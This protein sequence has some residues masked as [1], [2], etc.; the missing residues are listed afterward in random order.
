METDN[1][2]VQDLESLEKLVFSKWLFKIIEILFWK[3]LKYPKMDII[4]GHTKNV[5]AV[6]VYF[7]IYTILQNS[8]KK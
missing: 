5:Y 4:E 1:D 8:P 3:M 2:I 7:T 6:F